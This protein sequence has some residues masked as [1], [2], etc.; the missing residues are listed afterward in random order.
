MG[1]LEIYSYY[2]L[3]Y[4]YCNVLDFFCYFFFF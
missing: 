4:C 2:C 1:N 3:Y